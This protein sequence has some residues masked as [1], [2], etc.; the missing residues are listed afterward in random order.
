MSPELENLAGNLSRRRIVL[1]TIAAAEEPFSFA[2]LCEMVRKR[3]F[4]VSRTTVYRTLKLLLNR[5]L[6]YSTTLGACDRVFHLHHYTI[7][8]VCNDCSRVRAF[9]SHKV[10]HE[11]RRIAERKGFHAI[12]INVEVHSPCEELR[13]IGFCHRRFPAAKKRDGRS[14]ANHLS[15]PR[16]RIG[17]IGNAT[18]SDD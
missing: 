18:E 6:I 4:R 5:K 10:S 7:F 14:G 12:K 13:R 15:P 1:Q 11:L 9:S 8:C 3:D 17:S 16:R 2:N